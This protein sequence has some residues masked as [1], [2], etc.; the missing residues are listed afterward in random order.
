MVFFSLNPRERL[1]LWIL[2]NM[3]EVTSG[4]TLKKILKITKH[5][6]F[7]LPAIPSRQKDPPDYFIDDDIFI[8]DNDPG[9]RNMLID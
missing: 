7:A 1:I 8:A 4:D 6:A 2:Q 3:I 9:V 5:C